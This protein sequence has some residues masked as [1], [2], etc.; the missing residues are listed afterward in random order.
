MFSSTRNNIVYQQSAVN[1][2]QN[3]G[4]GTAV[5]NQLMT[6]PSFINA[7]NNDYRLSAG[8]PAIDTGTSTIATGI[9]VLYNGSAPDIGALE[10]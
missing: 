9:T 1:S 5:S 10:Y 3:D 8:S 4:T 2:V 7:S 6:N